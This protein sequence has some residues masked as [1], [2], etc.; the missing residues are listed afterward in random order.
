MR[1]A[2]LYDI[3]GNLPALEAV[4]S[5]V[6]QLGVGKIVVGGDFV[7]GPMTLEC[8][9]LLLEIDIPV[10]FIRGNCETAVFDEIEDNRLPILPESVLA[11][12]RWT[13][14]QH[15]SKHREFL[16][17]LPKTVTVRING[18]GNVLFCHATPK[19]DTENFT[20]LTPREKLLPS[21][22]GI[23]E[24][25]VICGHTH[26]QFDI[27]IGEIR[28]INAGSVGMPFGK[29]GA[30][31]LLLGE[32]VEFRHTNFELNKAAELILKTDYPHAEDF[33]KN[34]VLNAPSEEKMLEILS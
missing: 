25:L 14:H 23:D 2:A 4:L 10:H 5:D 3:H 27:N 26:M 13:A 29:T 28:V 31:W 33:V 12:I 32:K 1:V 21:F 11:D 20:R 34:N 7:L 15:F 17:K 19:S 18:L 30:D 9:E 16:A 6:F 22:D 8:L 24:R